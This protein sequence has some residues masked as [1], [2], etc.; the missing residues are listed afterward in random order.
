MELN[1]EQ[2]QARAAALSA[3]TAGGDGLPRLLPEVALQLPLGDLKSARL[4]GAARQ[5]RRELCRRYHPDKGR[6]PRDFCERVTK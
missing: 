3:L 6:F 5:A 2:E 1:E 4:Q